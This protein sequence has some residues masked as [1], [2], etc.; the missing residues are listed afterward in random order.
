MEW[1]GTSPPSVYCSLNQWPPPVPQSRSYP[2]II[3]I[4]RP[5]CA[6]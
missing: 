5:H 4:S 6:Y 2:A 1:I 3:R